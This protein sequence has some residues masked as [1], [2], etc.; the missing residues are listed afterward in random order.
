MENKFR[1][2]PYNFKNKLIEKS[3]IIN[4]MKKLNINDFNINDIS[5]YQKAMV[6]KSYCE[7]PEYKDFEHPGDNCLTL[8]KEAYETLEFLGDSILGS[9]VSSYIYERFHIIHKQNEGFL[10]KLKIRLVCGENLCKFSRN[11]NLQKHLIISKHIEEKC[12]GR[13]N[14]NILEDVFESFVGA[15]YLDNDYETVKDFLIKV[16]ETH[17]DFTEILL[18]DNNYKDQISRYFQQNFKIYPKYETTKVDDNFISK[19]LK[20]DSIIAI[21][22]GN[23]KK[24][25]EQDVSKKA[26]K[27]FNVI[28]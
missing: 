15:I 3:D 16:I 18:K 21:G 10:T 23:S 1:A 24:K 22:N 7:L 4:I 11:I 6:H 28:T 19:I 8:Q 9:I 12:S 25:A 27:H 5:L 13:D 14:T 26:L 17:A 20:E 2:D